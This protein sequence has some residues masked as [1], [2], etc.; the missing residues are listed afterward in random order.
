MGSGRIVLVQ[1]S[2]AFA[3]DC[4]PGA[5]TGRPGRRRARA[6]RIGKAAPPGCRA[7]SRMS[8]SEARTR[9]A[10]A[11][12]AVACQRPQRDPRALIMSRYQAAGRTEPCQPQARQRPPPRAA[13]GWARAAWGPGPRSPSSMGRLRIGGPRGG[14][15]GAWATPI[16]VVAQS[17]IGS[18]DIS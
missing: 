13:R 15:G 6:V 9:A 4:G 1:P 14:S 2:A 8:E 12:A 18:V 3:C 10:A 5:R 7:G 17:I 11:R 16:I